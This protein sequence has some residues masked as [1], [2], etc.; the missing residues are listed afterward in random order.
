MKLF[1]VRFIMWIQDRTEAALERLDTCCYPGCENRAD[2]W[3]ITGG[4]RHCYEH[5]SGFYSDE[6]FCSVCYESM[7]PEER[8]REL[9]ECA[10]LD[11]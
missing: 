10:V 5:D 8:Q 2:Y 1:L 6:Y 4:H 7:T 11:D 3:C 9:E